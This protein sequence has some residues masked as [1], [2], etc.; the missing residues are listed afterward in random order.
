MAADYPTPAEPAQQDT[1]LTGRVHDLKT[2]TCYYRDVATG[3]KPFEVRLN[4]RDFRAGDVLRLRDWNVET[5]TYTGHE[6]YRAVSY[7]L[8]ATEFVKEGFAILGLAAP[9]SPSVQ[10]A[11][12]TE[13]RKRLAAVIR[14]R[15]TLLI[16]LERLARSASND[17]PKMHPYDEIDPARVKHALRVV[18]RIRAALAAD[19]KET[20]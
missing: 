17:D 4:D 2:W 7:V 11:A 1:K 6:C 12:A 16:E 9:Q 19:Q 3:R 20:Q 14:Q 10:Q 18:K 8:T 13:P 5:E 15:D